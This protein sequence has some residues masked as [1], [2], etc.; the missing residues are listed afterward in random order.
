MKTLLNH[1]VNFFK[2]FWEGYDHK[3]LLPNPHFIK[4]SEIY[5]ET[6]I[7]YL[8]VLFQGL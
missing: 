1:L 4:N 3:Y 2:C 8:A 6:G 5:S 7:P